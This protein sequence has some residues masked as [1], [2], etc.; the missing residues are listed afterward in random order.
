[1]SVTVRKVLNPPAGLR[2]PSYGAGTG[3]D[4]ASDREL[5]TS[6]ELCWLL[7][8]ATRVIPTIPQ[9]GSAIPPQPSPRPAPSPVQPLPRGP[10]ST[11]VVQYRV[12]LIRRAP[13]GTGTQGVCIVNSTQE[14]RTSPSQPHRPLQLPPSLSTPAGQLPRRAAYPYPPRLIALCHEMHRLF[15]K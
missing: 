14:V 7:Q 10:I 15:E 5:V 9:M 2:S 8:R 11:V 4:R 1:M 3:A 13:G 6:Q 12:A